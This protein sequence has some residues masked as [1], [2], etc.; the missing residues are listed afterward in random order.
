MS[1][2]YSLL[3]LRGVVVPDATN[4]A[5]CG[6]YGSVATNQQVKSLTKKVN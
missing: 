6:Q 2:Q 4:N 1:V 5:E 3:D